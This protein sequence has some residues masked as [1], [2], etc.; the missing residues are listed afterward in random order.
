MA[1]HTADEDVSAPQRTP[2]ALDVDAID[3]LPVIASDDDF[4][5]MI[6]GDVKDDGPKRN[7]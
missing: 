4:F 3:D 7:R 1:R 5:E 2:Q 6:K